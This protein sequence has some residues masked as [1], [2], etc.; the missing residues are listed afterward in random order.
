MVVMTSWI[1]DVDCLF[2]TLES[3]LNEWQQDAIF[4]FIAIEKRAGVT[5]F[6]KLGTGKRNGGRSLLHRA[7]L[8]QKVCFNTCSD[9]IVNWRGHRLAEIIHEASMRRAPSCWKALY[10][11]RMRRH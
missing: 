4:F 5:R 8:P 1:D 11:T 10:D 2:S 6:A 3:I 9:A 7:L